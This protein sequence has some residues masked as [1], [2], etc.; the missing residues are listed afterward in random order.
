MKNPHTT[1]NS[2]HSFIQHQ[3]EDASK[4]KNLK[5]RFVTSEEE[6]Y[7]LQSEWDN[8]IQQTNAKIY[9]T[10]EWLS[11]WWRFYGDKKIDKLHC[12][13]FYHNE[14]LVGIAPLYIRHKYFL[15]YNFYRRIYFLG[16]DTSVGTSFGLFCDGGPSD[17][18]DII[19][20]PHYEHSI[21]VAFLQYIQE[22]KPS[23]TQ[24]V[25]VDV[26]ADSNLYLYFLPILRKSDLSFKILEA[27]KSPYIVTPDS[28]DDFLK[29]RSSSVRRRLQ[30]SWKEVGEKS[31]FTLNDEKDANDLDTAIG[32]I[33]RLHQNRWNF[34]GYPGFFGDPRYEKFFEKVLQLFFQR[35]W[36]WCKTIMAGD[37]CLAGRLAFR[38]KGEYYDYLSGI[39]DK[40]PEMKRRPGL[41]LLLAMIQ[42]SIMEKASV[43]DL[44]RGEESYKKDFTV[45][46]ISNWNVLITLDN[47]NNRFKSIFLNLFLGL[48]FLAFL[49]DRECKLFKVTH[50]YKRFPISII[51][52]IKFR[53][54]SFINKI[55]ELLNKK[56]TK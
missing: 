1:I 19:S 13:L 34:L 37:R 18:L 14:I 2:N 36:L 27:D 12:L 3:M 17:Y 26:R 50:N 4:A 44:L 42:D 10:F 53:T 40:A 15:G 28:F 35:G 29:S 6:F 20:L 54:Q 43:I 24:L 32:N 47:K 23:N 33:K 49:I 9:Q 5:L 31:L 8:L 55:K 22:I 30:Q 16:G 38:Y 52:F 7:A 45:N 21:A 46:M 48:K 25:L 51:F 39:D 11:N 56:R 41:V